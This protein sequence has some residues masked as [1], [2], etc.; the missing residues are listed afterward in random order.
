MKGS[1]FA[2][3]RKARYKSQA[4][5]GKA[6]GLSRRTVANHEIPDAEISKTVR[7]AMAALDAG[8]TDFPEGG[9]PA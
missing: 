3:W 2:E 1:D 8:M 5:A 4:E 9:S 7:L 6:L